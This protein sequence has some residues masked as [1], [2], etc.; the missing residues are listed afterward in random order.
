MIDVCLL[1]TGGTMPLPD[2][3]LSS[4]LVRCEGRLILIDCGEGTQ[5]SIRRLGWG[6][7]DIGT[8]LI[9]HFHADHI[10]GL[11]GLLLTI[12]NSG[13]GP[14]E[15]VTIVGP[16]SIKKV[17]D[18][19]RIIAPTLPYPINCVEMNGRGSEETT[20]GTLKIRSTQADHDMN[21]LAYRLDLARV[22]QFLP[23][24]ALA[25]DL[26]VRYWKLLQRGNSVTHNERVI[27]PEEVLGPARKGLALGFVTDSRP[28]SNLVEFFADVDLLIS[29]G[30]YGDP[31]DAPK[32][33]LNKHMTFAEAARM[34]RAA[35]ASK[36]CLTHFTPA[37][38]NPD[39]F[40]REAQDIFPGTII[41][42]D[43]FAT[44]L[45]FQDGPTQ[46]PQHSAQV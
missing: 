41:G 15:P 1:G 26:P 8:I 33:L 30:T 36:L 40:R 13:R 2:R 31:A 21:C 43:H 22:P 32:A 9:T 39:Y 6:I 23:E 19:L 18:S 24:K 45:A 5:V 3:F 27:Q 20:S 17:V 10:S 42:Y 34:A 16:R 38:P 44:T 14:E 28:T 25:L 37:M 7:R 29:E 12:G 35:R 46:D 11:P 4:V